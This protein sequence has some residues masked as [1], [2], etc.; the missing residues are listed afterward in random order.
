MGYRIIRPATREEWLVERNKGIGSSEVGAILGKSEFDTAISVWKRKVGNAKPKAETEAMESGHFLEFATAAYFAAKTGCIIDEA[1][2]IDWLAVDNDKE[3]LR[4]SPDRL[5]WPKGTPKV[6][7]TP[8]RANILELKSTGQWVEP[9]EDSIPRYWYFQVQYQMYV[10]R[11]KKCA[12]CWLSTFEGRRHFDYCYVNYN[13]KVAL[14][15]VAALDEFWKENVLKKVMP[16]KIYNISDAM[17]VYEKTK[18]N[19]SIVADD[20]T[21]ELVARYMELNGEQ[22]ELEKSAKNLEPEMN[23]IKFKIALKMQDNQFLLNADNKVIA[24]NVTRA[25]SRTFDKDRFEAEQPEVYARY[26]NTGNPVRFVEIRPRKSGPK[27]K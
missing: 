16:R 22:K 11:K 9:N 10:M 19:S 6:L 5:Y 25:G 15:M 24:T 13:E 1:S 21:V 8:G 27:A 4:V 14:Q 18:E 17:S 3:Y 26:I 23:E 20:E 2:A 12:V 7:R